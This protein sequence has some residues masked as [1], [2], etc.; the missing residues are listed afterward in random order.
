[1]DFTHKINQTE[2]HEE[3]HSFAC[4]DRFNRQIGA[5]VIIYEVDF[6]PAPP[7]SNSGFTEKPGHYFSL[8]AHA[9]RNAIFYGASQHTRYFN[10]QAE[11]DIAVISYLTNAEKR[12]KKGAAGA[13][14]LASPGTK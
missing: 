8:M 7:E 3:Y 4:V 6:I 9:T 2:Y 1:M 12:A 14:G 13:T 11:R 5:W 10:T